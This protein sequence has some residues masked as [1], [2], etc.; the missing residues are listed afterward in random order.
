MTVSVVIAT[1]N[2][3]RYLSEQIDSVLA[4][5]LNPDEIIVSDDGSTDG[6][7]K[8]L[9]EYKAKYPKLFRLYHNEGE[10]GAHNNFK[11]AFQFVTC[12][13][14]APCDQDDIWMPEKLERSVAALQEG[15]SLVFCQEKI[16]H[17]NGEEKS[18]P[19]M[20]PTLYQSI[21]YNDIFGHL[22]VCRREVLEL[23]AV[24]PE[25]TYD[26]GMAL[27]AAI[28]NS[29]IGIDYEGCVWRRHVGVVTSFFSDKNPVKLEQISKWKKW[30]RALRM[31][32]KGSKSEVIARRM[33]SIYTIMEWRRIEGAVL[34]GTKVYDMLSACIDV[35]TCIEQQT[36]KSIWHASFVYVNIIR[37]QDDFKHCTLCE[38]IGKVFYAFCYP[39]MYWYDYHEYDSL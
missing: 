3:E 5:T 30:W 1:Y 28:D 26:W 20:M 27:Y 19:H 17:E 16:R 23:F 6:T 24:A 21:F 34:R 4:Q 33:H 2:G 10:H 7:W 15:I 14:V 22:M 12:D 31:T 8:I 39:A 29:G 13:L 25:M 37:H 35:A 32:A 11:Y 18:L 9:E 36:P 38:K